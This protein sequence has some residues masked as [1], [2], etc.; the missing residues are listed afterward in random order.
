MLAGTRSPLNIF[1]NSL[2]LI[3][4]AHMVHRWSP[5]GW[6]EKDATHNDSKEL[7]KCKQVIDYRVR[8]KSCNIK[9][10]FPFSILPCAVCCRKDTSRG[11]G[12]NKGSPQS[13]SVDSKMFHFIN[14]GRKRSLSSLSV[15]N[16]RM[17]LD[18]L[19]E[20]V[21]R[22]VNF[23]EREVGDKQVLAAADRIPCRGF[24]ETRIEWE[25]DWACGIPW[26]ILGCKDW[27]LE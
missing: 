18:N 25:L 24:T 4:P 16:L 23:L 15:V 1:P 7:V 5:S 21:G 13:N 19:A 22:G 6:Y 12:Y 27:P 20:V 9:S 26:G 8:T 17:K 2:T 11:K 10:Q 3:H 14:R